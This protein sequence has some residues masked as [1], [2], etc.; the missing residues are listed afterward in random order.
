MREWT[1]L[2][3]LLPIACVLPL[4]PSVPP[5][6]GQ[7]ITAEAGYHAGYWP[8]PLSAPSRALDLA[9]DAYDFYH[10]RP[11]VSLFVPPGPMLTA[12]QPIGHEVVPTAGGGYVYRPLHA[13]SLGMAMPAQISVAPELA[14]DE[15]SVD[16]A[17]A[18]LR[19]GQAK[20]AIAE[21]EA[22][23]K[24][25]PDHGPALLMLATALF[26][27]SRWE[28]SAAALDAATQRLEPADWGRPVREH[29]RWFGSTDR[30][31]Q[32]LRRL[33]WQVADVP[34]FLPARLL[35]GYHYAHLGFREAGI[36][37]LQAAA[38]DSQLRPLAVRLLEVLG[39]AAPPLPRSGG[40]ATF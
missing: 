36:D 30:Y 21:A 25:T 32:P 13:G 20:Q 17:V 7:G 14:L 26:A 37:H 9:T 40:T 39:A 3:R 8:P 31:L 4:L 33:E 2:K 1:S 22:A 12:R 23:L 34:Q 6:S 18:H 24:R 27:D 35:L 15:A 5:A 10:F 29:A 11:P 16:R 19:L 28:A 38:K